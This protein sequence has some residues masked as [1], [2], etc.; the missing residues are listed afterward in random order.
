MDFAAPTTLGRTGLQ[1]GR[2]GL[3]SSYGVP[4]TALEEAFERGCNYWVWGSFLKG[5]RPAMREGIKAVAGK[6]KRDDLVLALHAYSHSNWLTERGL[7]S[8][9]KAAGIDHVDV[10]LLGYFSKRPGQKLIDGAL[11][12]KERG[13]VRHIGMTGHNRKVFAPLSKEG[14]LDVFHVRYNA[15]HRGAEREVFGDLPGE[16]R[17][18]VVNFTAT[19][20]GKLL[21]PKKMP[22]GEAPA[23]A[24]DCYR[25]VLSHPDVDLTLTGP[26]T[27]EQLRENLAVLD[28]GPMSKD[29]LERMRRIGAHIYGK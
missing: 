20:W 4:A 15:V 19:C 21:N 14:W 1:V 9:F 27:A 6:G 18:G 10:L 2:L 8:A 7:R 23:T 28:G 26:K 16:D 22:D 29:E 3:A 24:I 17:P 5:K 11:K 12:L 25:Y 13:L